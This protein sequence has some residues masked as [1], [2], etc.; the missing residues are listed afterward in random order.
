MGMRELFAVWC[1]L[2][3]GLCVAVWAMRALHP[4]AF[5]L[6]LPAFVGI[7]AGALLLGYW[8]LDTSIRLSKRAEQR[9]ALRP[10][11]T[12]FDLFAWLAVFGVMGG[13]LAAIPWLLRT[14][15]AD[16]ERS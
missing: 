7:A 16:P 6:G 5:L 10:V 12:A 8:H 3:G 14:L 15:S 2:A 9:P 11:V 1:G 13:Y 4:A